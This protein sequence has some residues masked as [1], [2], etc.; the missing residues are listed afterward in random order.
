MIYSNKLGNA[1]DS[2]STDWASSFVSLQLEIED[3]S[4][5]D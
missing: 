1:S 4:V 3:F 2:A 5:A